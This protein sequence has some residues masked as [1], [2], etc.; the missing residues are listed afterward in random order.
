[1]IMKSFLPL[2]LFLLFIK[3]SISQNVAISTSTTAPDASAMLD[4]VSSSKGLLIPRLALS[5]TTSSSPVTSPQTSLLVYNTATAGSGSTAVSPG[6]YY[7]DGTKW[8]AFMGTN[9]RD[10]SLTGNAG[11]TVGTNFLGTTDNQDLQFNVNN[12]RSGLINM[13]AYQTFFG[14]QAGVNTTT[15]GNLNSFFGYYSALQNTSGNANTAMGYSSLRN[16]TIGTDNTAL[17]LNAQYYNSGSYNTAVGSHVLQGSNT[18]A[19]NTGNYNTAIGFAAGYGYSVTVGSYPLT[20]GSYNTFLGFNT[21]ATPG[22]LNNA[23]A[24]GSNAQVTTNNAIVL[25]SINGVNTATVNTNVGIGT[26]APAQSFDVFSKFQVNSSGDAVK[27]KNVP[28]SWPSSQGT[29]NTVLQNDGSGNLTWADIYGANIQYTEG[30]TDIS[31]NTTA[32]TDMTGVSVTFTPKH[33]TVYIYFTASGDFDVVSSPGS[34]GYVKCR[35]TNSGAT[36]VYGRAVSIATDYDDTKGSNGAWNCAIVCRVTG[37]T[38]GVATTLK[39][40]WNRGGTNPATARCYPISTDYGHRA[41]L[42]MD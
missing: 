26:T 41:M 33:S 42:I 25:G 24:I 9:G 30:S 29:A 15:A 21:T 5:S 7:W 18:V 11:T 23:T 39:A 17:G 14:Y 27:I 38:P 8:V 6:F 31:V 37:L 19:S 12:Y 28:Y 40:Q 4:I 3:S 13:S 32:W 35:I 2:I 10:W 16:N 20:S 1:M 22:T 34:L 36:T